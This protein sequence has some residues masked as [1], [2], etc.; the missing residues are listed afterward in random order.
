[1]PCQLL[2]TDNPAIVPDADLQ[3]KKGQSYVR[4]SLALNRREVFVSPMDLNMENGEIE[5]PLK[6]HDSLWNP[7]V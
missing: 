1:M 7:G 3:S 4:N 2:P 5:V 6:A